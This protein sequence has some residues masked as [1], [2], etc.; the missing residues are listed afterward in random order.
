MNINQRLTSKQ[1]G[2]NNSHFS[3]AIFRSIVVSLL[4]LLGGC[5]GGLSRADRV[6]STARMYPVEAWPDIYAQALRTGDLTPYEYTSA[7]NSYRLVRGGIAAPKPGPSSSAA[8]DATSAPFT[9]RDAKQQPQNLMPVP[10]VYYRP[11]DDPVLP[12]VYQ[13]MRLQDEL[14]GIKTELKRLQDEEQQT[15]FRAF[16]NEDVRLSPTTRYP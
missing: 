14:A 12:P 5:Y 15:R 8:T 3:A 1:Y 16:L 9:Q 10:V 2:S 7:M 4:L 11:S 13:T 6:Y